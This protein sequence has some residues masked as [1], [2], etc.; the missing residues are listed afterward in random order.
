M[1]LM[2]V[3]G[4]VVV[5]GAVISSV[6]VQVLYAGIEPPV[7]TT[8]DAPMLA[9]SAPPLQVVLGVPETVIPLVK[10]SVSG[11]VRLIA[12]AAVLYKVMVKV[13]FAP[14]L[15]ELGTKLLRSSGALA[16]V[17]LTINVALAGAGL[18]PL[19]VCNAPAGNV[20]TNVH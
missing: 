19:P 13:E 6:T 9:M 14:A 16:C 5:H 2:Y 18:L 3:H 12:S 17:A 10:V 7:K 8:L 4:P 20:L 11:A 15:M 1:V